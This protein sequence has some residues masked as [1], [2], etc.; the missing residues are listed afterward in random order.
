MHNNKLYAFLEPI[1]A[2]QLITH[3]EHLEEFLSRQQLILSVREYIIA[4]YGAVVCC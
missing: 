4:D 2:D 3:I 1:A